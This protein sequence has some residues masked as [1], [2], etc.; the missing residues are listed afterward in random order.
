MTRGQ[1]L[2]SPLLFT[3]GYLVTWVGAGVAAFGVAVAGGHLTGDVLAW[4][5]A[6][7][8][9]AAATVILAAVYE[10]TPLK[11][12]C[13]GKCRS[14]LGS[15]LGDWRGG[16]LGAFR[17]G[18]KNGAWCVGC[19]WALMASLFALGVM[20]IVWMTVVAGMIAAEKLMPWRRI[21][22]YG[23]ALILVGLGVLLFAA[24]G[25]IPGLA[26][27]ASDRMSEM[28]STSP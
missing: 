9:A 11:D 2:F 7:R 5:R 23:T 3:A 18:A 13:L 19:C 8:W 25:A 14:P 16:R 17:M 1:S 20:S 10:L 6:G 22:T 24:P 28:E 12:V 4:D 15:L 26:I 27:H 21:A